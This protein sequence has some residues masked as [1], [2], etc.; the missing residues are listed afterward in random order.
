MDL[1]TIFSTSVA[2]TYTDNDYLKEFLQI[3]CQRWMVQ[4]QRESQALILYF[5][6]DTLPLATF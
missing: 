5:R 3:I 2:I 4:L 1:P 6:K